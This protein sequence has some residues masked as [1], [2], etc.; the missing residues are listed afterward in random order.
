[1][2]AKNPENLTPVTGAVTPELR[3]ALEN[4]RWSNRKTLS[5]VIREAVE[6]WAQANDLWSPAGEAETSEGD[7]D[8]ADEGDADKADEADK[9]T[10]AKSTRSTRTGK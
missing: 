3:E 2:A 6:Y 4:H 9:T 1:M 5:E 8:K 10:P 7:A